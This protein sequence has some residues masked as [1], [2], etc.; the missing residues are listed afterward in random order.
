MGLGKIHGEETEKWAAE[1]LWDQGGH[2]GSL[3]TNEGIEDL[4]N[5]VI[6]NTSKIWRNWTNL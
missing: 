6:E 2:T 3:P 5:W 4:K 1:G